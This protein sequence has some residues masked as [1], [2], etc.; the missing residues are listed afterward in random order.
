MQRSGAAMFTKLKGL[1]Q[2]WAHELERPREAWP[3]FQPVD[4]RGQR[5]GNCFKPLDKGYPFQHFTVCPL[6]YEI[7]TEDKTQD[8]KSNAEKSDTADG[9]I[10]LDLDNQKTAVGEK[11]VATEKAKDASR[12][13]AVNS[14]EP[15]PELDEQAKSRKP[16]TDVVEDLGDGI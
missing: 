14:A 7:L 8:K 6:C 15:K 5:C 12:A 11:A 3:P 10:V 16:K 13:S 1:Y 2:H 9:E 4:A